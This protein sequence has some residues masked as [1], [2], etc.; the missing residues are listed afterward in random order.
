MLEKKDG[1]GQSISSVRL[2]SRSSSRVRQRAGHSEVRQISRSYSPP[3]LQRS[4]S[5]FKLVKLHRLHHK[6]PHTGTVHVFNRATK[7]Y[8]ATSVAH[9]SDLASLLLRDYPDKPV[10]SALVDGG[11]DFNPRHLK[12]LLAFGQ[13]W[14]DLKLDCLM[15]I[16]HSPGLSAYN[17]LEHAWAVLANALTGVTLPNH[18]PGELPPE[19]QN[20]SEDE[21]Q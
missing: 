7:F 17:P 16:C 9:A 18:L 8:Q 10:V 14:R 11:P 20:L 15:L 21:R 4:G 13:L 12:N 6:V 3:R 5:D 2:R 19:E 1:N